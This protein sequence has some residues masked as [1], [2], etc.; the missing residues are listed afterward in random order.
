M[1]EQEIEWAEG[2]YSRQEAF[3]KLAETIFEE[4]KPFIKA[5][6]ERLWKYLDDA[7]VTNEALRYAVREEAL[8]NLGTVLEYNA[9]I[10]ADQLRDIRVVIEP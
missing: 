8:R 2:I 4:N 3:N 5:H 10:Y 7:G 9:T 6:L 1:N